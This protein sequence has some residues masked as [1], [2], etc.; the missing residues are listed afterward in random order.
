LA[1]LG[2]ETMAFLYYFLSLPKKATNVVAIAMP[3]G[4]TP[5]SIV[6]RIAARTVGLI[7]GVV[8]LI[9]GRD[10]LFPGVPLQFIPRDDIY[11]EWTGAFLHSPPV[12]SPEYRE[13]GLISP[14]YVGDKLLHQYMALNLIGMIVYKVAATFCVRFASD[15]SGLYVAKSM[16]KVSAIVGAGFVLILRLFVGAANSASLDFRWHLMSLAYEAFIL[17]LYGYF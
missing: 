1:A 13:G 5:S 8:L 7:S 3:D 15:G 2:F 4:K 14:L 17:G 9:A 12:G 16:W 10:L 6:S 11:L